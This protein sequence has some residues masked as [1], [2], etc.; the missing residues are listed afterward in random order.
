MI[1]KQSIKKPFTVVVIILIIS[2]IGIVA[3]FNMPIDMLPNMEIPVMV[4]ATVA[5]GVTSEVVEKTITSPLEGALKGVNNVTNIQSVSGENYSMIIL[6]F[7]SKVDL[8]VATQDIQS[9]LTMIK[10]TLSSSVLQPMLFKIDPNMMPVMSIA[11]SKNGM[12]LNQSLT[13]LQSVADK[14]QTSEGVASVS[15]TGLIENTVAMQ[16]D[17]E[18]FSNSMLTKIGGYLLENQNTVPL[19]VKNLLKI[20]LSNKNDTLPPEG[21]QG[22]GNLLKNVI[23][24]NLV[25]Q[26]LQAQNFELPA[27][28]LTQD[29]INYFV[30]VGE[31]VNTLNELKMLPILSFKIKDILLNSNGDFEFKDGKIIV[32]TKLETFLVDIVKNHVINDDSIPEEEKETITEE[33][34][35]SILVISDNDKIISQDITDWLNVLPY[36]SAN[37][38]D[39]AKIVALDNSSSKHTLINGASG[40]MLSVMK[41][42]GF[43]TVDVTK[44]VNQTLKEI[45][46]TDK[47]FNAVILFD[48][49]SDVTFMMRTVVINLGL[50]A[51][52]AILILLLF[53][54]DIR[55]TITVGLSIL[56]S[57]IGALAFM[58]LFGVGLNIVSMGGVALAVGMLVDNSIVVIENIYRKRHEGLSPIK[59]AYE[60]AKQ[61]MGAIVASTLTTVI[62]FVPV[63]FIDGITKQIFADLALTIGFSLLASLIVAITLVPMMASRILTKQVKSE[64]KFFGSLRRGYVK[65]LKFMLDKKWITL[66]SVSVLFG[67]SILGV[68]FMDKE[69]FPQTEG[70]SITISATVDEVEIEKAGDLSYDEAV[71]DIVR[72]MYQK[73]KAHESVENVGIELANGLGFAGINTGGSKINAYITLRKN[74]RGSVATIKEELVKSVEFISPNLTGKYSFDEVT[75]DMFAT[76]RLNIDINGENLDEMKRASKDLS[77]LIKAKGL[78]D[79]TSD[80]ANAPLEYRLNVDKEKANEY[81]LYTAQIFLAVSQL[82][83]KPTANNSIKL[84]E[85]AGDYKIYVYNYNYDMFRW[86]RTTDAKGNIV[87]VFCEIN[88][89]GEESYYVLDKENNKTIVILNDNYFIG[90]NQVYVKMS[91]EIFYKSQPKTPIDLVAGNLDFSFILAD[92]IMSQAVPNDKKDELK[93]GVPIYKFLKNTSFL[94]KDGKI[95]Y[96]TDSK[97]NY[98]DIDDNVLQN[99]PTTDKEKYE[100]LEKYGIPQEIMK[101]EGNSQINHIGGDRVV[102]LSIKLGENIKNRQAKAEINEIINNYDTPKDILINFS[103][104]NPLIAETF[105]SMFLVLGL[106]IALIYLVMVA[107]F[108]SLKSPLIVMFTLPL[109]FTGSIILLWISGMSL[110]VFAMIG[111]ILLVGLVVNNGIVFVDY[112]NKLM[113]GGMTKRDAL[114]KAGGD[115]LRPILMT[116]ITTIVAMLASVLDFSSSANTIKP[117]AVATI[118]GLLYATVLTLFLVPILYDLFNKKEKIKAI[119]F[120][121]DKIDDLELE[122][123]L[124]RKEIIF[125]NKNTNFQQLSSAE[126]LLKTISEKKPLTKKKNK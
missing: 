88:G 109:A 40:V 17:I 125:E 51:L 30:K 75:N 55:P 63:M 103:A 86:F 102:T 84:E 113:L 115:R 31:K 36:F 50:G 120:E 21:L 117:M 101:A 19:G 83:A 34:I 49:G 7:N 97:G 35:G 28:T 25:E 106:A 24:P 62:V 57:V 73:F 105:N 15:T 37:M 114:L 124:K 8:T 92:P 54:K 77:E 32:S 116:A 72:G 65:S 80:V 76:N 45:N 48:Q 16:L 66:I 11:I 81:G 38:E 111:L 42:P 68:F 53:L 59:A 94:S 99:V 112:V 90:K 60:G 41:Q 10:S 44:A 121:D 100:Y 3:I 108:Q 58:Y 14:L 118:G 39:V 74:K 33:I 122:M 64:H 71:A 123:N 79:V 4:V 119:V 107:Q 110:S 5:P 91:E 104:E 78:G 52:F 23:N 43:S 46:K 95:I 82:M 85:S 98:L 22:V 26:V 89:W 18:H 70:E 6:Q 27:G 126:E 12:D 56:I 67:V 47:D 61:V 96:K 69:M 9:Q 93:A 20:F 1:T 2:I 13:Y 87:R 29:G